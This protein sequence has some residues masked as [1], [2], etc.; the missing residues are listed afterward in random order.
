MH[1]KHI[2]QLSLSLSLFQKQGDNN[3]KQ[4]WKHILRTRIKDK[5]QHETPRS[6][7]RKAKNMTPEPPH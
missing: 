2:D 7:N 3:P 1:E 5:T 6:R 4:N